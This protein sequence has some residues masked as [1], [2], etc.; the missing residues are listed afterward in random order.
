MNK[1]PQKLISLADE[2]EI[3]LADIFRDIDKISGVNT[4]K[5]LNAFRENGVSE[6]MFASSDGYGYTD[7]GRDV[8]DKICAQIFG[9]ESAFVRPSIISGTHAIAIALFGLLRPGDVMLSVTGK[10][11]DTLEEVIGITGSAGEGS[12]KDFG[13][14]YRQV[15]LIKGKSEADCI[16]FDAVKVQLAT[17]GERAKVVF[18]QRSKGYG[19]RP[20]LTSAT[21]KKV[22]AFVHEISSAYVVVDNCYGEFTEISEPADA[23]NPKNSADII[24]GSLIKNPGGG[25]AETGGYIAG[26]EKAVLLCGNRLTTPG[27]GLHAG[28]SLGQNKN[29]FRGFFYA[30]HTVAQ[31][32]KTAHFAAY[33]LEKLGYETSPSPFERRSDI[34]QTVKLNSAEMLIKFCCGIQSGSPVDAHLAPEPWA[35]PGYAHEVIMAAGAFVQGASIELSADGPLTPPYM[36]FMQGAL[37]Y[38]SGKFG[39]M[40]ALAGMLE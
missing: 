4:M 8:L 32:I 31:A 11:Y 28:A 33:M 19:D 29:M 22:A 26:T 2:T 6:T 30:P 7:R 38:E 37:T 18:I 1:F 40:T 12:L 36:A 27:I 39:V 25:M 17:V 3:A 34:I 10:P 23:E 5:V 13:V 20:T 9:A 14:E 24:V 35:M 15:D 16:D 21:I